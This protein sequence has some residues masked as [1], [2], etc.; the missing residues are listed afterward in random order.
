MKRIGLILSGL[1]L[2]LNGCATSSK[3]NLNYSEIINLN[4]RDSVNVDGRFLQFW[5]LYNR[6]GFEKDEIRIKNI[7]GK[8]YNV[9][10]LEEGVGAFSPEQGKAYWVFYGKDEKKVELK[11]ARTLN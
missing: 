2:L 7:N 11:R 9:T 6:E 4:K 3:D 5:S 10:I 8:E 1:A